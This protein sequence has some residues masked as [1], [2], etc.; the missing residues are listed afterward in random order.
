MVM[1]SAAASSSLFPVAA[2]EGGWRYDGIVLSDE[3]EDD[4]R[5]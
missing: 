1:F 3:E 5:R 4:G 2:V